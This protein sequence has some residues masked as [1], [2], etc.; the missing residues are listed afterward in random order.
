MPE[1]DAGTIAEHGVAKCT[2]STA[3]PRRPR[4]PAATR[5]ARDRAFHG[6]HAHPRDGRPRDAAADPDGQRGLSVMTNL[7]RTHRPRSASS[8]ATTRPSPTSRARADARTSSSARRLFRAG[9][10]HAQCS[11]RH[12]LSERGR[13]RPSWSRRE[14][15]HEFEILLT[16]KNGMDELELIVEAEASIPDSGYDE[17]AT[18]VADAFSEALSSSAR[19]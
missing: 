6:R 18:Q 12:R 14:L 9:R 3:A 15:G 1:S 10:R 4:P 16:T 7:I 13:A 11:R 19:L 5:A 2:S 8:S 17:V